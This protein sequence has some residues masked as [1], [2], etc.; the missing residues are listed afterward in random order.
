MTHPVYYTTAWASNNQQLV[1]LLKDKPWQSKRW[2]CWTHLNPSN[3]HSRAT[4]A[5]FIEAEASVGEW[6]AIWRATDIRHGPSYCVLGALVIRVHF[7]GSVWLPASLPA[8]FGQD[9]FSYISVNAESLCC[10]SVTMET[11]SNKNGWERVQRKLQYLQARLLFC[12]F[13]F[14]VLDIIKVYEFSFNTSHNIGGSK[15]LSHIYTR[16][17]G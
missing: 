7:Q 5:W 15:P 1:S 17:K 9:V 12:L 3:L 4:V 10:V 14:Y 6:H 8:F 2:G 16:V 13:Q 11:S